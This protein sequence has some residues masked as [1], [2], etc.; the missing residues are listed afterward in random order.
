MQWTYVYAKSSSVLMLRHHLD[1]I[2]QYI[3]A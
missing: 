1:D 2:R 3:A